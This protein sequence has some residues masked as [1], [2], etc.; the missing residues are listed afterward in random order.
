M[1]ANEP[2]SVIAVWGLRILRSAAFGG[3]LF[4][5]G[6]LLLG[7]Q[8]QEKLI[9]PAPKGLYLSPAARNWPFDEV[10]LPVDGEKTVGWFL[11]K[12]GARGTILFS[13]GNGETVADGL[14]QAAIFRELGFNVLL[15]DYGGYGKSTGKPSEQRCYADIR[16]MWNYLTST[17]GLTANSIVL[18]GRS[19]GGGPT[20]QLATE[21][22]PAGI[23]LESAF[24]SLRRMANAKFPFL[25]ARAILRH[26]FDNETKI[27]RITVPLLI[28]HSRTDGVVPYVQGLAL[29][30]RARTQ[31]KSFLEIHGDH[32]DGVFVSQKVYTEGLD[33]YLN[34]VAPLPG[35][36]G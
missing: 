28:I 5:G 10:T 13:H 34:S 23:V 14:D 17:R 4:Y 25:P 29:Y 24:C 11:P 21:V 20:T 8:F 19:L 6:V 27:D 12:D 30:N 3:S 9:F 16:A 36:D 32:N 2:L 18:Y 33:K 22:T 26:Q 15:Y 31:H 7:C 1:E 35:R